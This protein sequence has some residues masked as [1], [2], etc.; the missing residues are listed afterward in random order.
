MAA[1]G[2]QIVALAKAKLNDRYV[3][4]ATG[5]NTFDCSG[6]TQYVFKEAGIS[7]PRTSEEQY[8]YGT[9]VP[10][11]SWLAAGDLVFSAGSDGTSADPGH[12]G[13]YDGAGGVI[14][15]PY[16]GATVDIVPLKDFGAVG[17]RRMP[18]LAGPD[19]NNAQQ[20]G[21]PGGFGAGTGAPTNLFGIPD[22]VF[23][24]FTDFDKIITDLYNWA[25]LFFQPS[26]YI[27]IGAGTFGF[28]FLIAGLILLA[29]ETKSTGG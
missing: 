6:L 19:I 2:A 7:I 11:A 5:P 20:T 23:S 21:Q 15:A 1:T 29:R 13:I 9:A 27:R 24:A 28:V 25:K 22:N 12:V 14:Q 16:T 3:Y 18:G 17:F 26:T 8:R 10:N 4:G